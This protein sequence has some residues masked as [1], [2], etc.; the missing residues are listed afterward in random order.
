MAYV[1]NVTTSTT[2][3][4]KTFP[5]NSLSSDTK[6]WGLDV[7]KRILNLEA[8]F[9]SAEINNVSRDTQLMSS[10]TRLDAAV[11]QIKGMVD[12]INDILDQ[13]G[14]LNDDVFGEGGIEEAIANVTDV[15]IDPIDSTKINGLN[16]KAGTVLA[17]NVVSSYVYA[18]SI[19]ASQITGGY[20]QGLT[21][22]TASSGT[23]V[24]TT[25]SE[26]Q[27]YGPN[28][29]GGGINGNYNGNNAVYIYSNGYLVL[30]G[31]NIANGGLA[32]TGGSL[33]ANDGNISSSNTIT[34]GSLVSNGSLIR[35]QLG[36]DGLGLTGAS[37]T[38][39]GAFVR[40]SSSERYKQDI[41]D[42]ALSYESII[43]LQPKTFRRKE[44]VE[45]YGDAAKV[46]PGF[47]AEDIADSDLDIFAFY[48]TN[49]DGSKVPEGVHYPELT[50]ALVLA[51]KHQDQLIKDLTAR[52]EALEA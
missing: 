33:T 43:A 45:E 15:V 16:L 10:Y 50:A 37:V 25:G 20:I 22:S 39:T 48:K 30:Q 31:N 3:L 49:P 5:A 28:G 6:L 14:V 4:N 42:L 35:S 32:V 38:S 7:E 44:E 36:S 46:Y 51:L 8:D 17:D 12:D 2:G 11:T 34:G 9:Q 29:Q 23:R 26:I 13:L 19:A 21:F 52:I 18:G 40:T 1:T 24:V 27:F 47:I 41:E